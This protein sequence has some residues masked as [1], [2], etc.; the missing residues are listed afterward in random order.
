MWLNPPH[1]QEQTLAP[2]Q[3]QTFKEH[4][5]KKKRKKVF[6]FKTLFA[7]IFSN[8]KFSFFFHEIKTAI[9]RYVV[10]SYVL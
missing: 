2:L 1:F 7:G 10:A 9:K 3:S 4:Q 8:L 5:K 6:A